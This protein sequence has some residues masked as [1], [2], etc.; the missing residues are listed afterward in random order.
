MKVYGMPD[1]LRATLPKFDLKAPYEEHQAKENAHQK[2]VEAWLRAH[3]WD[4]KNTGK[5]VSFPA[6]DGSAVYML[7]EGKTS[8]LIH[9]PYGDGWQ[10]RDAKFLPKSEILKRIDS[11]AK[12]SS[13]FAKREKEI[14]F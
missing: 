7:A 6:G 14:T 9:L 13:M 4:G 8:A 2:T 5:T 10:Y 3:G 1:E 12:L 11:A